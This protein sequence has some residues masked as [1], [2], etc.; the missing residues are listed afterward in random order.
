MPITSI[1]EFSPVEGEDPLEG[2]HLVTRELNDG[3]PMDKAFR[4]W[5]GVARARLQRR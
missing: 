1:V 3:R 2:Y 4:V 5:L